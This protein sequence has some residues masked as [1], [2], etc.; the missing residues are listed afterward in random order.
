MFSPEMIDIVRYL[1]LIFVVFG[2]GGAFLAD[3]LVVQ[4]LKQPIS[5]DL[6][7]QLEKLHR[8][9]WAGVVG[10]WITGLGLVYIRTGFDLA[11]FSP[12]LMSKLAI[13]S[14]LTVNAALIGRFGL[15][16]LLDGLGRRPM[17]LPLGQKI[18][19]GWLASL[20]SASWLMA[21]A[22]GSSKVLAVSGWGVFVVMIPG[23]YAVMVLG[24]T[25][26]VVALH[27]GALVSLRLGSG[28]RV[29]MGAPV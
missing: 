5:R 20:S 26:V 28:R 4:S 27:L 24:S 21:L 10:M 15:P 22:L 25:A 3:I 6:L 17:A 9:V 13:V 16:I 8:F 19:A 7:V 1:H 11:A 18:K 2:L 23:V 12:K 29:E 14:I